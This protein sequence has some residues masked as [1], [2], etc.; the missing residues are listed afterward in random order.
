MDFPYK[1]QMPSIVGIAFIMSRGNKKEYTPPTGARAPGPASNKPA[2]LLC[3]AAHHRGLK[4]KSNRASAQYYIAILRRSRSSITLFAGEPE[5][6][7]S[8]RVDL[9]STQ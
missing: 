6:P 8:P 9:R 2:M 7:P 5:V 4:I 1:F 3:F